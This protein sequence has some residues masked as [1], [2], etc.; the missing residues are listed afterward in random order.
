M[1]IYKVTT[2]IFWV[3][4]P[5]AD[6]KI[7]C[8]C[9][10]DSVKHLMNKGFIITE[11][12]RGIKCE[13]GP[14]AIL[15]SDIPLQ[16]ERFANLAEFPVLQMLYKQG[17]ILP[18]HPNNTG[19]KP[20]LIGIEGELKAQVE[21]IYY[22]NYGLTSIEEIIK[23]GVPEDQAAEMI[24][25]KKRFAFDNIRKTE[26]LIDIKIV[27]NEQTEI[28][29]GVFIRRKSPN[30]FE[31]AHNDESVTVDLNLAS[32]EEY[33]PVYNLGYHEIHREYFSVIHSGEGDGWDINRPCMASILT[34]HGKIYLI[35]AGP[36]LLHSLQSL[37]IGISEIE[38]IFHTHAHDD[39]FNGLTVLLRS[40]HKIKYFATP[41]VRA[42]VMKKLSVLTS[43]DETLFYRYFDVHDLEADRWNNV[44]GLEVKPVYSPHPVETTVMYFRAL[45]VDGYKTYAH[46]ADTIALDVLKGMITDDSTKSG[47]SREYY[48]RIKQEYLTPVCI[49]KID[50][51]GGLIHGCA[52]DFK[53]DKTLRKILSHTAQPLKDSQKE[54][55]E[56]ATFGATNV[57]IP[58]SQDYSKA[59]AS[60][61]FQI[62]FTSVP[63]YEIRMLMNC[64]VVSL[65]PGTILVARGEVNKNIFF[66]LSGLL[67]FIVNEL[68]IN[69]KLTAGSIA[70]EL[71][72]IM[73]TEA[74]G[75]YRTVSYVK[76]I[77]IPSLLYVEFLKRNGIFES[78][79]KN[80]EK[81]RYLQKTWLFGE[82]I[83]CPLKSM[84]AEAM[85]SET[86]NIGQ[87]LPCGIDEGLFMLEEGEVAVI[88]NEK[89]I[90]TLGASD[91]FGEE[92]IIYNEVTLLSARATKPSR[93]YRIPARIIDN[94]PVVQLKLIEM[95]K[96][97][98]RTAEH[99][100]PTS[101]P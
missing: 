23:V 59:L 9:P 54:I 14:N 42:S 88:S 8:G 95:F 64:P 75:T 37:G 89:Q 69:N 60:H 15:L 19:A 71:S 22:G 50:I 32:N 26:D 90:D 72:G 4:I 3:E 33:E 47:V 46:Y 51:G 6:L 65:N 94:I 12:K 21:Y 84:I 83:S 1:K 2:G 87:L 38:G 99:T 53:E 55:G 58:A 18:N 93:V 77:Q 101:S 86:I 48:D 79:R 28:K 96:K 91:F 80:I 49:K 92:S 34:W 98:M 17:L 45:W 73:G 10:A 44:E 66:I 70:G 67:E 36:N 25:L 39:H 78:A 56:S 76:A 20:M 5:D 11:E 100:V 68:G 13:T 61:Y 35:D 85:V 97:R 82:R 16:N 57:F 29:E 52:E 30:V 62:L 27:S 81:R 43:M 7:L 74:R 40:D 31:I 63:S 41:L 24:R